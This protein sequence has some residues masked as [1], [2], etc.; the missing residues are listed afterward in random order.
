MQDTQYITGFTAGELSPWLS[1]R[2][3]LQAY[4]RGAAL[5][6]NFEVLPY[7]GLQRRRGTEYIGIAAEQSGA[8]R[9]VPFHFSESDA[10]MLEF[11]PGGVRVYR[12]GILL[13]ADDD[14]PYSVA[15]PWKT[16][17]EIAALRFTQVNDV[18]YVT[19]P[20]C[21]PYRLERHADTNWQ[22]VEM[23]P[24]PFPRE[25]YLQQDSELRVQ[26][27][28]NGS[29]AKLETD[30]PAPEFTPEMVRN[31][32]IITEVNVPAQTY[33]MN[34]SISFSSIATPDL[35][36]STV[37][38]GTICKEYDESSKLYYYYTVYNSY[39]PEYFNGSKSAR[40]YP[41][42]FLPGVLWLTDEQKPYEVCRD[43]EVRT[44]GEWNAVW[45]LWRSYDSFSTHANCLNWQ[46]TRIRTFDQTAYSERQNWA[47]SGSENE[48]CRMVL[49]C[50]ASST[51]KPGA[52]IFF[53]SQGGM[54]EL[55]WEIIYYYNPRKVRALLSSFYAD[56]CGSFRTRNWSF[57][58]FGH[59]NGYPTFSGV[60][61]GRL[62]LGGIRGLPT[63]LIASSTGDFRN[64]RVGSDADAAL[65]LTLATDNQSRICWIYP[66]RNLLIGTTENEWVLSSSDGSPLSATSAAF[67]R[68]SSIGCENL[69]AAGVENTVFYV[70]RGGKRLREI[71]YKL[72]ADGYT[73]VDTGI[74]AEHL[75]R[76]GIR[77][78]AVQHGD[79]T[80]VWVL[81]NDDTL[82]VLTM[83][84]E[85]QVTA[86]QS[87]DFNG[88]KVLH[89]AA[90]PSTRTGG[91]ELWLVLQNVQSGC[92]SI[93]R[94]TATEQFMD[95][96]GRYS[97]NASGRYQAP[98]LAGMLAFV[99][100]VAAPDAQQMVSID[101]DGSFNHDAIG[102][103]YVAVP[104]RSELQT[105][106]YESERS[107]NS[108]RQLGRVRLRLL[109]CAPTFH[110]RASCADTWEQYEPSQDSLPTPYTGSVRVSHMPIPGVGQ[111]FS[112]YV[113]GNC[114]FRLLAMSIEFDFHG[115]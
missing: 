88:R 45:E 49:V 87:V 111:G 41:N 73:S 18:I 42:C 20:Y 4:R 95:G 2:F 13:S 9:L 101:N 115:K 99:Y 36:T 40:D 11:F 85:H 69:P 46:W 8:L 94:M 27:E 90:L 52:N 109:D 80:R 17:D 67:Q 107:F 110:Y 106:P 102:D 93:E 31:E 33:F 3:D 35:S 5:L 57:G 19:C 82:A 58:A 29:Y 98:H 14:T 56:S 103:F 39:L 12:D 32:H 30:S 15:T 66:S 55:R 51:D 89:L 1:S 113:D 47:V 22:C 96:R 59:R 34:K 64:F 72:E 76:S 62:W 21:C 7:G 75:F 37:V 63:T 43:W 70:Q 53:R 83:N 54:R 26:L 114:D 71:S 44:N 92:V 16:A 28:Q 23:Y 84:A 112:L 68:Q 108:I 25:T 100:P 61:Q 79:S 105:M 10:L 38:Y 78:W 97:A 91:D 50:R 6:R 74:L 60:H 86:W 48:P 24:E 65:H 77:E 104:Y 81:M